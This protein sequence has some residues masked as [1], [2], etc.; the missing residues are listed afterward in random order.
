MNKLPI[1]YLIK[2]AK[3]QKG[4]A[5]A[6]LGD[7]VTKKV[8]VYSGVLLDWVGEWVSDKSVKWQKKRMKVDDLTLTGTGP[9]WNKI[10]I[11]Q[12]KRSPARFRRL[13]KNQNMGRIFSGCKFDKMPIL[14]R[15][16]K[17]D[18]KVEYK[19]LDGMTR[20]IGA[21]IEGKKVVNAYVGERK[22]RTRAEIE[23]HVI[24]DLL[25]A[26]RQGRGKKEDLLVAIRY[27][28][29]TYGNVDELLKTRFNKEWGEEIK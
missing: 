6:S 3:R 9:T 20:V 14:V 12:A 23:A 27:L 16:E 26:Y 15:V 1:S 7:D 22:G 11:D 13:L 19:V 25:K 29:E 5:E 8:L 2:L 24:Y 4:K 18:K 21:I 10:I 28:R 17:K